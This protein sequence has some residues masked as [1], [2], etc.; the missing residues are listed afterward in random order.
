[1]NG[2][3]ARAAL[4]ELMANVTYAVDVVT[5]DVN[6][7]IVAA[8][9]IAYHEVEGA[10]ISDQAQV[11]RMMETMMPV[12]SDVFIM[13]EGFPAAD[14]EVPVF[15]ADGRFNGSI[16]VAMDMESML[17][18]M[19]N[20]HMDASKFQFTCL[21]TDGLELYDT[22]SD[23]I[24]RNLF[25][26]PAYQNYTMALQFMHGVTSQGQGYGTYEYYQTLESKEMVE[27]EVY[28]SSFGLYG[29]EWRLLII[30]VI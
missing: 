11:R 1:L 3:A 30:H 10:N 8:E 26:D 28:W 12:M 22:D 27:K 23:Q 2:T 9:P 18:D 14:M 15:T 4:N 19:V 20:T 16:S 5:I 24:G 7:I 21:Q 6:G 13:A 25:T 17:G 29:A